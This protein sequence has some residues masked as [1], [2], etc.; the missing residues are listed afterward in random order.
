A[1][2]AA[3]ARP[4]DILVSLTVRDLVAG[5]ELRFAEAGEKT[6]EGL[7]EPLRVFRVENE[8]PASPR[9]A[10]V[11]AAAT[12]EVDRLSSREKE[13]LTLVARGLTNPA[14]AARLSLSEHTVK[15][16]VANILLKLDL[17]TRSAAA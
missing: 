8:M 12:G 11:G 1:R 10:M 16:H 17:S 6:I 9:A 3:L 5:S 13:I 7:T 2:M 14:I 15:R 4:G